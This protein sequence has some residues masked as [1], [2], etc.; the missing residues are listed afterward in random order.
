M[1]PRQFK[2]DSAEFRRVVRK[3]RR[4]G[5]KTVVVHLVIADQSEFVRFGGP[6]FGLIVSKAVGNSVVRHRTYRRLRHVCHHLSG[7]IPAGCD[8]VIRALPRA[9]HAT[10]KELMDDVQYALTKLTRN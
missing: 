10:S 7:T 8:V 3:G 2:L 5:T 4:T 9:G 1:L 6:H